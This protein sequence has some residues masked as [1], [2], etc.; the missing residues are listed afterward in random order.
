VAFVGITR[1]A[2][3][4]PEGGRNGAADGGDADPWSDSTDSRVEPHWCRGLFQ[5]SA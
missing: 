5:E 3:T 4:R 2:P 1:E